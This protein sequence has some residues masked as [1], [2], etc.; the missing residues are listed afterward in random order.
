LGAAIRRAR[1]TKG[2]S[3]E[4]LALQADVD[5]GYLGRVERGD[6]NV[7]IL[8]LLRICVALELP[9]GQLASEADL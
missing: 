1:L 3:Q 2:L 4:Q 5:R 9:L 7:A 8:T 6:N